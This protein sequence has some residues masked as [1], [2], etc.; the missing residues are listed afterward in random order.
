[1]PP[2]DES[3]PRPSKRS[4][5]SSIE[6][7]PTGAVHTATVPVPLSGLF[8]QPVGESAF[9]PVPDGRDPR[10]LDPSYAS[11]SHIQLQDLRSP[12]PASVLDASTLSCVSLTIP[13]SVFFYLR[14]LGPEK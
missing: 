7:G 3:P 14:A 6:A 11:R 13:S 10:S 2:A 1:M 5:R 12:R 4:T 9:V 8:L